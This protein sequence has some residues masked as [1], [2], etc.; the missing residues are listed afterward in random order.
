VLLR[1]VDPSDSPIVNPNYFSEPSD[2]KILIKAIKKALKLVETKAFRKNGAEF[3]SEPLAQCAH[4]SFYPDNYWECYVRY[5]TFS[6]RIRML[7]LMLDCKYMESK[8]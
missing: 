6:P 7:L 1:S 4:H 8:D 5:F 2:I 3:Y